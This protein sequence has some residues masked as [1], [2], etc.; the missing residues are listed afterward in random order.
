MSSNMNVT[1]KKGKGSRSFVDVS[2]VAVR[3]HCVMLGH[4]KKI[5]VYCWVDR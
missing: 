2:G 5:P 4:S 3:V 1:L